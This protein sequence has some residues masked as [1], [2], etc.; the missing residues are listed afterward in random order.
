MVREAR[1]SARVRR[2]SDENVTFRADDI[3]KRTGRDL[4]G[5]ERASGRTQTTD[6][7]DGAFALRHAIVSSHDPFI[8]LI[9]VAARRII[10][11]AS[12]SYLRR[13]VGSR[14]N[15]QR[16]GH[17]SLARRECEVSD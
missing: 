15:N 9:L 2:D 12:A 8:P 11:T 4:Y 14:R 13:S 10:S 7:F 3:L 16:D 1:I 6:C 5:G 17:K